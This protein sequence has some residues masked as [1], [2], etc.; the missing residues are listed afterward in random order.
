MKTSNLFSL[1]LRD[2]GKGLL[3]AVGGAVIAAVETSFQASSLTFNW[4]SI[5]GVAIAAGLSYLG[6]N[7]F[8]PAQTV[9]P[10]E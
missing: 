2:L 10:I 9:S 1:N 5:M 7:F 6:K 3:V 4:R 8:T